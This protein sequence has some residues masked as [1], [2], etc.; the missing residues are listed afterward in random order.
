MICNH[1]SIFYKSIPN[2]NPNSLYVNKW[3]NFIAQL[4]LKLKNH[5]HRSLFS[6]YFIFFFLVVASIKTYFITVSPVVI[7]KWWCPSSLEC[8]KKVT[9]SQMFSFQRI[10]NAHLST[11]SLI[12]T[13]NLRWLLS[14]E[15]K[16]RHVIDSMSLRMITIT[17]W[18]AS[19]QTHI[20]ENKLHTQ[21]V[22]SIGLK[23]NI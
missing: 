3:L 19:I 6:F 23:F 8:E 1:Q 20:K 9:K 7:P 14:D 22:L 4:I 13:R 21:R 11:S 10:K 2:D 12:V 17:A 18:F 5:F 16:I 15:L